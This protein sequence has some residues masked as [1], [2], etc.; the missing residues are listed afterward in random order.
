MRSSWRRAVYIKICIRSSSGPNPTPT[1]WPDIKNNADSE[2]RY[3]TVRPRIFRFTAS[4]LSGKVPFTV[5]ECMLEGFEY[6]EE[7]T[8]MGVCIVKRTSSARIDYADVRWSSRPVIKDGI[9][10]NLNTVSTPA[11]DL[12]S[13]TQPA[14]FTAWTREHMFKSPDDYKK[15]AYLYGS[16]RITENYGT[17]S[18]LVTL[19][20]EHPNYVVRDD[21]GLE[22]MQRIISDFGTAAF[23]IEWMD[24]RDEILRLYDI[25]R[26]KMAQIYPIVAESPFRFSNYGGNVTPEVIGRR[27]FEQYYLPVYAEA[28]EVFHKA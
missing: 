19:D 17:L 3:D 21:I 23:C 12:T 14:G 8:G 25:L 22:P 4:Q 11:G 9:N 20:R 6:E 5:Y 13:L 27:V 1:C 7:I 28:C 16:M 18:G 15:F 24:N 26:E 10:L 2:D